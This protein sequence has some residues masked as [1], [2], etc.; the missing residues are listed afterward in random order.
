MPSGLISMSLMMTS[1]TQIL[2][3]KSEPFFNLLVKSLMRL[4][5]PVRQ[6]C[7]RAFQYVQ[8]LG[9][10]LQ[11][12]HIVAKTAMLRKAAQQGGVSMNLTSIARRDVQ[13]HDIRHLDD[14]SADAGGLVPRL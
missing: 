3:K 12:E 13:L 8:Q 11:P 1:S 10:F 6:R 9:V 5:R 14:P 7:P 2:R 4:Q